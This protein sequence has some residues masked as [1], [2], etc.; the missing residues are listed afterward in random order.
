MNINIVEFVCLFTCASVCV[1][2]VAVCVWAEGREGA[3]VEAVL[4]RVLL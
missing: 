1:V 2:Q 3:A 4:I